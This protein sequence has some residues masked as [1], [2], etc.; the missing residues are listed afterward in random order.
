MPLPRTYSFD[1]GTTLEAGFTQQY[2]A[3][4]VIEISGLGYTPGGPSAAFDSANSYG[5]AHFSEVTLDSTIN[6]SGPT[7]CA[8]EQDANKDHYFGKCYSTQFW[9]VFKCLDGTDTQIGSTGTFTASA[10]GRDVV[11]DDVFRLEY[12][13]GTLTVKVNG[14]TIDTQSGDAALTTGGAGFRVS[15]GNLRA[16]QGGNLG[17]A[18]ADLSVDLHEPV[19]GSTVF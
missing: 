18:G 12:S 9:Q 5:A 19:I 1:N 16:W 8:K 15:P 7:V 11:A 10:L 14:I 3:A 2:T 17:A 4:P 6:E 13:G